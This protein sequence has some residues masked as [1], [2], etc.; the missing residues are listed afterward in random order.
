VDEQWL[1]QAK[2]RD[3][4]ERTFAE[5]F[6]G[7]RD[8][9]RAMVQ[10]RLDPRLQRRIDPSDVIQEAYLEASKRLDEYIRSPPMPLYLWLRRVTAQK[11]CDAHR[12]HLRVRS[13]DLR[14]EKKLSAD[15]APGASSISLADFLVFRGA[16]PSSEV[17]SLEERAS[18]ERAIES[19]DP[20][21]RE[22]IVLRH[23]EELGN[24][25]IAH[26]LGMKEGTA[27]KR[28]VRALGKLKGILSGSRREGSLP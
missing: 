3:E 20:I 28:Y 5:C 23:V 21:D 27:C 25:E 6:Q 9:L 14:R 18:V 8:R 15:G 2:D 13:R 22:I 24:S 7:Y 16:S 11:L 1:R 10:V 26:L 12:R 17:S 19:L 4:R